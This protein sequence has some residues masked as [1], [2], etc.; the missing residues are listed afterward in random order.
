MTNQKKV[1]GRTFALPADV[2]RPAADLRAAEGV[3]AV[4]LAREEPV[5]LPR[6]A[7]RPMSGRLYAFDSIFQA[8]QGLT[9]SN[10]NSVI[11][12]TRFL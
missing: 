3:G 10:L 9:R 2:Q 8:L 1:T 11:I 6:R 7:S 4:R 12:K 5:D